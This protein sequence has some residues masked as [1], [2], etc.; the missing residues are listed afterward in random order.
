MLQNIIVLP[1]GAEISSG[2]GSTNT[3][4]NCTITE[5]VN[6]GDELSLGSTCANMLEATLFDIGAKLS[7]T[8]G[9]EVTLYKVSE[10][11]ART[12]KGIFILEKPTRPSAN[13]L[14]FTAYDR[15]TKLD[16]DLTAWID[17]LTEWPYSLLTFAGMV[18]DTCGLAFVTTDVPNADFPVYK[19]ATSSVTGRQLMKW[20]G[21]ICCRFCRANADGN[22]EF[23]WYT[24]SDVTID[25][26][27]DR[28]YYQGALSYET[29]EVA[30]I[31]V[32]QMRLADSES[33]AL[34]PEAEEGANSYVITGNGILTAHVTEDLIHY[35]Q[36][37]E[38]E[39]AGI[40]Y[41]PCEVS[42]PACMDI[43]AGSVVDIVDK[44][45]VTVTTYVMTKTT[46]GQRDTLQCT[47][48]YRRDSSTA[49]AVQTVGDLDKKLD[50]AEVFSRLT[51][52]GALKGLYMEDG[53]LYINAS[54]ILA[55]E[56]LADLIKA[57]KI[58]SV[59]ESMII[60]LDS[61]S[62]SFLAE[63]ASDRTLH[64]GHGRLSIMNAAEDE[65]IRVGAD[66]VNGAAIFVGEVGDF[67]RIVLQY[68]NGDV[69]FNAP[70]YKNTTLEV[71]CAL[72]WAES[73]GVKY[74]TSSDSSLLEDEFAPISAIHF[75]RLLTSADDLDE[76]TEPGVYRYSTSSVP[77]NCPYDNAGMVEVLPSDG[78]SGVIQRVTRY[79]SAGYKKE[80]IKYGSTWLGWMQV[81]LAFYKTYTVTTNSN[82]NVNTSI[83][84]DYRILSISA[85]DADGSENYLCNLYKSTASG[86]RWFVN[87][88]SVTSK[89]NVASTE[90][91][92]TIYYMVA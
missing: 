24:P 8:A 40:T 60:N 78:T 82:G 30:P 51:K 3:I 22:I 31:D 28:Y 35:L 67:P 68:I 63:D 37:I 89:A 46:S 32:V 45:G 55:G 75:R 36:V 88:T 27:G 14:K 70:D 34:W 91:T 53:E 20:I 80:R 5:C 43:N 42:I 79:G 33:G 49:T 77:A 23:A 90:F 66:D 19:P 73:N 83:S 25:A 18:C 50:T 81:P 87:I 1:D 38:E 74:L 64:L 15:I 85:A 56:L 7:L 84:L 11:G 69:W 2:A 21:E 12:K 39:L 48:S 26:V 41:T 92:L 58:T 6:D 29:Y 44:N 86:G 10:D 57:G 13:A 54:Y 4:K 62:I 71:H 61:G 47:G 76:L 52:N 59:D 65:A 9:D 16:K 17:G 72:R